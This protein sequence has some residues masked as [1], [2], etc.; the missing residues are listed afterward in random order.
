MRWVEAGG[1]GDS[2]WRRYDAARRRR[3]EL[4][5]AR[6]DCRHRQLPVLE[7]KVWKP[8]STPCYGNWKWQLINSQ[9]GQRPIYKE[10]VTYRP[11]GKAKTM[12]HT[13]Y[14]TTTTKHFS[15]KQIRVG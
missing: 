5:A 3:H 2:K 6:H 11:L 13:I 4:E 12:K 14:T 1:T 7:V 15:P 9:R 8:S 10:I